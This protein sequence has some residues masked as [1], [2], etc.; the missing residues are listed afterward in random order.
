MAAPA[1]T[2]APTLQAESAWL[3]EPDCTAGSESRARRRGRHNLKITGLSSANGRRNLVGQQAHDQQQI[4]E[5]RP[6]AAI[7]APN[8]RDF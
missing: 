3:S 2:S 4:A 7:P 1:C 5:D 6:H 8:P